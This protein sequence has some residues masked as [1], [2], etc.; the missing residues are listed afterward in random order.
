MVF[1]RS[2]SLR[3]S[4]AG[5]T[6]GGSGRLNRRNGRE[7]LWNPL[8]ASKMEADIMK[9]Q[10]TLKTILNGSF[11]VLVA[12]LFVGS[13]ASAASAQ[14]ERAART[15]D[16]EQA[17]IASQNE[18]AAQVRMRDE[19]QYAE[20]TP[21]K[22]V[23]RQRIRDRIESEQGLQTQ[24]REQLRQNLGECEKLGLDDTEIGALF[25]ESE[26]LQKQIR[27]QERV[28]AMA[29]EGLPVDPVTQKLQEGRRKGVSDEVLEKVCARMDEDVRAANR[30]MEKAREAGVTPGDRDAERRR[31][32]EMAKHMF[33]GLGEGDLSQLQERARIRLRD[34]S[35]TTDDLT[36]AA[37]A[38]VKLRAIGIESERAARVAGDALQYGYT[39]R[40]MRLFSWM[41]MTAK[42][43][44]GPQNDVLDTIERGIR[45]QHQLTEMVREMYEHGWMGP[46]DEHGGKGG[47]DAAG[48]AGGHRHGQDDRGESGNQGGQGGS[49]GQGGQTGQ[50]GT[51]SG[52]GGGNRR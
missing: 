27:T 7:T 49:G 21:Q 36:A 13:I 16:R 45:N 8:R 37:E 38:T 28:L 20:Q 35:C 33:N 43:N 9:R 4:R 14:D 6:R 31:T 5:V 29:R 52:G 32:A 44:G 34:G 24:E 11:I 30:H 3:N 26:P 40:E 18:D 10:R 22:D 51:G 39:A 17:R 19:A 23:F 15:R 46:A 41:I 25:S 48:D 1:S 2:C 42:A 12:L 50:G 47:H